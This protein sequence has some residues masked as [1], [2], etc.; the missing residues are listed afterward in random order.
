MRHSPTVQEYWGLGYL[1]TITAS[2]QRDL[3]NARISQK[4]IKLSYIVS[5]S[6]LLAE[7]EDGALFRPREGDEK[8]GDAFGA[9]W[10]V[11]RIGQWRCFA[12]KQ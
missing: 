2:S 12:R 9:S 4:L 3:Q 11:E 6:A 1:V 5:L 7:G 10:G 8:R